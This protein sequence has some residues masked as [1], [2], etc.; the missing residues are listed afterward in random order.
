MSTSHFS[1]RA[2]PTETEKECM[3]IVLP[4]MPFLLD[5]FHSTTKADDIDFV[6]TILNVTMTKI[7]GE[8]SS[9][10][11]K[12]DWDKQFWIT[13]MCWV[14]KGLTGVM[15]FLSYALFSGIFC[16]N[17]LGLIQGSTSRRKPVVDAFPTTTRV[18]YSVQ[19]HNTPFQSPSFQNKLFCRRERAS[20][21]LPLR[22]TTSSATTT[23]ARK[24]P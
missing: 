9:S 8:S 11:K 24:E 23:E 2:T 14:E 16:D 22:T 4:N 10:G 12:N 17:C 7:G 18:S 1:A 6:A 13:K 20:K 15:Q 21:K 19:L 5:R 3:L